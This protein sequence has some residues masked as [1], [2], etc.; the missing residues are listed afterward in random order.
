MERTV[1]KREEKILIMVDWFAPG[2]RAGGP[3]QSCVNVAFA[4]K[5]RYGIL[6][7]TSDT[8]YGSKEPYPN[9]TT[10]YWT[11]KLNPR[12]H[13]FY[14]RKADFSLQQIKEVIL[15]AD[16][17]YIYLNHLFSPLYVVY[18]LWLKWRGIIKG[19]VVV[20]PRGALYDSALSI[21]KYKKVPFLK[22]FRWMG[23]HKLVK[24]HA[25]NEREQ[26][27]ILEYFPGSEVMIAD[28]LPNTRQ[29]A[30]KKIEKE[31][32]ELKCIFIA[33][34]HPIKNLLLLLQALKQ[35]KAAVSLTI[36]GPMEDISYWQKC[37]KLIA[38]FGNNI[39][40][41]YRGAVPNHEL[42]EILHEHHLF[43]LPTTG[44]NFG[45]SIFESFLAGR[46]VLISDQTPWLNLEAHQIGWDLPL[47]N[48][49]NFTNAIETAAAWDQGEFNVW[50]LSAWQYA[51]KFIDNPAL[52]NQ[53]LQLFS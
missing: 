27:A 52:K 45:H 25:T 29:P 35:V 32:G 19:K 3:I 53:Y 13:V 51:K 28:N 15:E 2:Y 9:I 24:F 26:N 37:E 42:M 1:E 22:L 14:S 11:N 20:C 21:K 46:P 23:I 43:I 18:P 49:K 6:V 31:P 8:D 12:I 30:F 33:R 5:D 40:L 38:E 41:E 4:L 10:N 34:I 17:D 39:T 48:P 47:N 16:A 7:L 50:A 36:I 44:E